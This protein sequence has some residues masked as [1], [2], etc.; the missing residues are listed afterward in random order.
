MKRNCTLATAIF[1]LSSLT[2]SA[3]SVVVQKAA[4]AP[5]GQALGYLTAE[6][7][8]GTPPYTF[9]WSNGSTDPMIEFLPPGIYS[10][11]VTDA[12]GETATD[13]EEILVTSSHAPYWGGFDGLV[14]C[15]G[16][17]PYAFV[18]LDDPHHGPEPHQIQTPGTLFGNFSDLGGQ[19]NYYAIWMNASPGTYI[20]VDWT[21]ALGCPGST[22]VT[23]SSDFV[24]PNVQI[25]NVIGACGGSNGRISVA[26][27]GVANGQTFRVNV[28][29]M[30][31][32]IPPSQVFNGGG[33]EIS[34]NT[35]FNFNN[36]AAGAYWIITDPDILG[37]VPNGPGE[38]LNCLDSM[39][40]EVPDL[41]GQ[42]GVV[43]GQVFIDHDQDCVRDAND[44][45]LGYRLIEFTPGPFY[46]ITENN[47]T[48]SVNLT[49]GN[50]T[51]EV[52]G[53]GA[54]LYPICPAVQPIPVVVSGTNLVV[55]VSDSSL[56]PLDLATTIT[57]GPARPGFVHTA[58]MRV[59]NISGQ[60]SET[61][62]ATLEFD[63]Q[64]SFISATP[65]PASVS[66]NTVTWTLPALT[67]F[68]QLNASVQLQVPP[69]VGLLGMPYA[70]L[71]SATQALP[72]ASMLNNTATWNGVFTGSY[73][74][75][76][77]LVRTSSGTSET[78][79]FLNED[80]WLE[81]TIRF[82][83]TGN[84]TA[85]TVVVRD[86]LPTTLDMGTFAQ[87]IA[88]HPF[89]VSFKPGRVVE[90][91]FANILLPDSNVNEPLSHGQ[92]SF[93]IRPVDPLL[94]GTEII[95]SAS[96]YFDFNPP[97]ITEP[98]VLV[99]EFSTGSDDRNTQ[100][101]RITPNPASDQLIVWHLT[102]N[103]ISGNLR[104]I[105]VDGRAVVNTPITNDRMVLDLSTFSAGLYVLQV[106]D[107]DQHLHHTNFVVHR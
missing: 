18:Y 99:A 75:N 42:C 57:A 25:T 12:L 59:R 17:D 14:N 63:P 34:A 41:L 98:S 50:Y 79:Y 66:G 1:L 103:M 23:L 51:M 32:Q 60:T 40:V 22:S 92:V 88:S 11:T 80:E 56:V 104:V 107:T 61:V 82:Q 35:S 101:L 84:D 49:N 15:P 90:W 65:A 93:R 70:H 16:G 86:V 53:T 68:D 97:V 43:S 64:M 39:Y 33:M 96:I 85:F 36:L 91:R 27:G 73:D 58:W 37:T 78:S 38:P 31:G 19:F 76:D 102:K 62:T 2:C 20:T 26:V 47:G 28:R 74:P 45:T 54:E 94:P 87:G 9:V 67:G 10:L 3:F 5:C 72:E 24:Q 46:A 21:D 6:V 4:D 81:Y 55:N 83:N 29:T 44:P 13:S 105:G 69:D 77:K 106:R 8:G 71:A 89:S 7:Q 100:K 52:D 95:N 48:Y 30:D